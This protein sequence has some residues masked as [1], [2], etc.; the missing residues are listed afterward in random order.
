VTSD[1]LESQD[2]RDYILGEGEFLDRPSDIGRVEDLTG[3][4]ETA[5][6]AGPPP[7]NSS[8]IG[9]STQASSAAGQQGLGD[10]SAAG[11]LA[12]GGSAA[13]APSI[14]LHGAVPS[15]AVSIVPPSA[16]ARSSVVGGSGV[17]RLLQP[18]VAWRDKKRILVTSNIEDA[19]LLK[20]SGVGARYPLQAAVQFML[21]PTR[22]FEL[23]KLVRYVHLL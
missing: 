4:E 11:Q 19:T 10:A 15:S 3:F 18:H 20:P 7:T 21:G 12:G 17:S 22:N 14:I 5:S 23:L 13:T 9:V 16:A 6:S 2:T 8:T 1:S